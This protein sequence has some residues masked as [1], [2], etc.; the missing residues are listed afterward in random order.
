M[1][2]SRAELERKQE[3]A[4]ERETQYAHRHLLQVLSMARARSHALEGSQR[5]G[6]KE[7]HLAKVYEH[8]GHWGVKHVVANP[9]GS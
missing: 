9:P 2:P 4:H 5:E 3:V 1:I 7:A 8:I 6:E